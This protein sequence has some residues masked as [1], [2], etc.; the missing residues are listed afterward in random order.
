M[1]SISF[2]YY[3]T[4]YDGQIIAFIDYILLLWLTPFSEVW[5]QN[6]ELFKL[7]IKPGIKLGIKPGTNLGTKI[8]TKR[9]GAQ[10]AQ[11]YEVCHAKLVMQP[12]LNILKS[13][14]LCL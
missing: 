7:G 14:K 4:Y 5:N 6:E 3:Q 10:C 13:W 2:S 1:F 9:Q 12:H 11:Q 8:G